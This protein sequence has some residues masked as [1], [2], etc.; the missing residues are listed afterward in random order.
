MKPAILPYY[1][2]RID[3]AGLDGYAKIGTDIGIGIGF[4]PRFP[5]EAAITWYKN[6]AVLGRV[7]LVLIAMPIARPNSG[8]D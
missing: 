2:I 6:H 3:T 5:T 1:P 4:T 8:G 7:R